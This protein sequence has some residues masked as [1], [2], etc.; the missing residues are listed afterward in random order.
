VILHSG[1]T[2]G[3]GHY[4]TLQREKD[5]WVQHNDGDIRPVEDFSIYR[6]PNVQLY[7]KPVM[8]RFEVLDLA[9]A[10]A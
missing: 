5:H 9:Q 8:I 10:T 2:A 1:E 6:N 7:C 3:G 4:L